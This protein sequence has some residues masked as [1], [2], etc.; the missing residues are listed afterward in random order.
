M[1]S[2]S[3][4]LAARGLQPAGMVAIRNCLHPDDSCADFRSIDDVI[5]ANALPMYDRMQD[6]PHIDHN[7][8]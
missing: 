2:L 1:K 4:L 5:S 8:S 7:A 3:Q 6:G